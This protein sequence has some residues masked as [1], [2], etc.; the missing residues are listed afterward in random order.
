V[1]GLTAGS[2]GLGGGVVEVNDDHGADADVGSVKGDGR[3]DGGL[4]GA[5]GEAV[6]GVF[7]VATGNDVAV[8]EE[9]SGADA[10][11]AV[12]GVGVIGDGEGSLAE[13]FELSRRDA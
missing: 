13:V 10:E 2:A 4:L 6:G 12:G 1:D 5:G 9:E 11:V 7:Y 3:G 8:V